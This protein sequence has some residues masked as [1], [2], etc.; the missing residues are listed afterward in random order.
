MIG[1]LVKGLSVGL[2]ALAL[3]FSVVGA[4]KVEAKD[5]ET[6]LGAGATFPYP[7]Y[8][9]WFDVYHKKTG[10]QVNYQAIGSGG[11]IRQLLS[12]TV[13]FGGTD[14]FMSAKEMATAPGKILH[15]PTTLGAVAVAYNL[16]GKPTL[17]LSSD[18]LAGIFLGKI[19]KWNDP[20]ITKLNPGVNLP[21]M[22]IVVVHRSDGS[23]TTNIF[24]D[25]LSKVNP[26]WGQKVGKGKSVNWPV[27]L[28]GKG[29]PGVAGLITQIPGSV[30]YVEIAYAEQNHLPVATLQNKSGRFV[31]PSL[32]SVSAAANVPLPP[33]TRVSI[34]DTDAPD[35][36]PIS[37]FTWIILYKEQHYSGRSKARAKALVDLLWWCIHDAQRHNE[38]LLY[39]KLPRAAVEQDEK[40]LKSVTYDGKPIIR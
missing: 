31:K 21:S 17:K 2:L 29:N 12:R 27:G 7:L 40:I 24:T 19:T 13:D 3:F 38:A 6:L 15:I 28:G 26:K 22:N 5:V 35:G 1:K 39:G 8:S 30:G 36:Y 10:I 20:S 14:A 33:D 9:K 23:G 16:P 18:A 32:T 11:G 25:Y 34:T 37:G 4:G